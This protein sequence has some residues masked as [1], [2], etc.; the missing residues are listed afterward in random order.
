MDLHHTTPHTQNNNQHQNKNRGYQNN[1]LSQKNLFYATCAMV[2]ILTLALTHL[3]TEPK[4]TLE[5]QIQ[6]ITYSNRASWLQLQSLREATD[7]TKLPQ[8]LK[9]TLQKK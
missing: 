6:Q 4:P 8:P 1:L 3:L 9:D 7:W 5:Q 2:I